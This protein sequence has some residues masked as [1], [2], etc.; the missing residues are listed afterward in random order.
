MTP[1]QI[2]QILL[3]ILGL[4]STVFGLIAMLARS[5]IKYLFDRVSILETRE[6]TILTG[7]VA[8]AENLQ[9]NQQTIADFVTTLVDERKYERRR[10]EDEQRRREGGR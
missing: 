9:T 6:Q 5:F 1:T 10:E 8:T 2:V 4:L 3:A 7:L